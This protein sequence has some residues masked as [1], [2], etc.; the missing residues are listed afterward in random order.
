MLELFFALLC[1]RCVSGTLNLTLA[2]VTHA[3]LRKAAFELSSFFR[4]AYFT[5][6]HAVQP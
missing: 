3:T 6:I 4:A 5:I 1:I 2:L